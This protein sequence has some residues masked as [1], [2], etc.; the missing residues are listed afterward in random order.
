M[1]LDRSS[2]G[3]Y[4]QIASRQVYSI[5]SPSA[6][7]NVTEGIA[8]GAVAELVAKLEAGESID[9]PEAMLTTIARRRAIDARR[10][11][12]QRRHARIGQ[13]EERRFDGMVAEGTFFSMFDER[14]ARSLD[15][16]VVE[17]TD[18]AVW[19]VELAGSAGL[20]ARDGE[21]ARRV[22]LAGDS[23]EDVADDLD[24]AEKTVWNRITTIK[25]ILRSEV[26]S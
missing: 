9:N 7:D 13:E 15:D 8:A 20:D 1:Y 23:I 3:E 18:V 21:I 10:R 19:L 4:Y 2:Y 6:R 5:V 25:Q 22:F 16:D 11:W 24:M 12:K 17:N 14:L 26:E